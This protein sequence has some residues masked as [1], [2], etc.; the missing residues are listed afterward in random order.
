MRGAARAVLRARGVDTP[1]TRIGAGE[2]VV[3]L[4]AAAGD[5]VSSSLVASLATRF[6]VIAPL[7]PSGVDAASLPESTVWLRDLL[8]G[9][10]IEQAT[11][12]AEGALGPLA[13]SFVLTD[14]LRVDRLVLLVGDRSGATSLDALVDVARCDDDVLRVLHGGD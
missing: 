10:G 8:D 7:W 12:V 1:Y 14:P 6:R 9:L 11:V 2:T 3:L 4:R 5:D 13:L